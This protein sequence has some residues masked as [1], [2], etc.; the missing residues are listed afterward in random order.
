V[1]RDDDARAAWR[2]VAD[3]FLS[4]DNHDRFHAA[5][6]AAGL[7]HPGALKLLLSLTPEDP[8]AMRDLAASMHCDASW[9]TA[10]VDALEGP[11][12]VVRQTSA[13]DRRVKLVAVT[14]AGIAAKERAM[15]VLSEP[16]K[17]MERLTAAE[18][19]TLATLVRKLT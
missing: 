10:L 16:P 15:D 19:R 18:V 7:P 14:A 12:Y 2:A 11:G 9:V 8:P 13:V 6:D 4:D 5:C 1:A 17:A 3:L